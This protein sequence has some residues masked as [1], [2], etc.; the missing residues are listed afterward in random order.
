MQFT[1]KTEEQIMEDNLFPKGEYAFSIANAEDAI[2]QKGN[3][4]IKMT[5]NVLNDQGRS[6]IIYD[7]LM[8]A[9]PH[10]LRHCAI[11]CGLEDEYNSGSLEPYQLQGKE[12]I[13][14][15]IIQEDKTGRYPPKNSVVDY[16]F[17]TGVTPAQEA[18]SKA[19]GNAY[20]EDPVD[21][22]IPF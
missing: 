13:L 7:Y 9:I 22:E 10:K 18:H 20:V 5:L 15:L 14:K 1:P 19:K 21:D 8:E 4:M 12:G 2:S 6:Q 11:A 3:P 16:V 17:E